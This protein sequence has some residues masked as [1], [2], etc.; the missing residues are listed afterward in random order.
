MTNVEDGPRDST[1][2]GLVPVVRTV[3]A[4]P[5]EQAWGLSGL[6]RDRRTALIATVTAISGDRDAA[7]ES[8]DEAFVRAFER[9]TRVEAMS[10]PSGWILTVALNHLRR[11]KRRTAQRHRAEQGAATSEWIEAS[12]PRHE[13]WAAVAAL[14]RRE[15]EAVALRYLA[16]LTEPQAAEVMGIAVGTVGATLTAARHRLA[17]ALSIDDSDDPAGVQDVP[18]RE[19]K[20]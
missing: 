3:P 4:D 8:V 17:R 2:S 16:D 20:P 7:T 9:R 1:D 15:R 19:A 12:D 11:S 13:V 14:P 5:N 6:Y 10:S 18:T